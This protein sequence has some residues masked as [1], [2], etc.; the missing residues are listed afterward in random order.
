MTTSSDDTVPTLQRDVQRLLGRCLLRLQ[1][2][3]RLIKAIVANHDISGSAHGLETVRA[4][5]IAETG[6]KTLGT[7]VGELLGSCIS[8]RIDTPIEAAAGTPSDVATVRFRMG[9]GLSD[10]DLSR[11]ENDLKELVILRN[12]LVHHFIDQHDLWSID[13]CRTAQDILVAA[14][15]R[16]D[17]HYERL[18][19]WTERMEQCRRLA[20]EFVQSDGFR[21]WMVKGVAPDGTVDP[22]ET[23]IVRALREAAG[24]L[25][26]DGWA[27]VEGAGKWIAKRFPEQIPKKYGCSS[28]RQV[29]HESRVFELRYL[30]LNGSQSACYRERV[31]SPHTG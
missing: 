19:E 8:D 11:T 3:E 29:V 26:V 12:N 31:R 9:L 2:Y 4:S 20:H 24:A 28:W 15:S 10:A 7:L 23:G 5:R 1:Q 27:P 22:P 16:I 18:R 13:G 30:P 17:E 6:R 21:N 25:S 14:Y